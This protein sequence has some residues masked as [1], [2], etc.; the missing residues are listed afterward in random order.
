MQSQ[1]SRF[2]KRIIY[3]ASVV[4]VVIAVAFSFQRLSYRRTLERWNPEGAVA[5]AQRDIQQGKI[6]IY[7]HGGFAAGPVGVDADQISLIHSLPTEQAGVGC[8]IRDMHLRQLQGEY[9]ARYNK[10]IVHYLQLRRH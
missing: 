8:I 6:K 10:A 9:A 5:E 2:S 4:A 1:F 3:F 7:I